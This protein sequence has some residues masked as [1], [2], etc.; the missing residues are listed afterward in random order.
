MLLVFR[1]GIS[2]VF[3]VGLDFD[4]FCIALLVGAVR[5]FLAQQREFLD[6]SYH[7]LPPDCGRW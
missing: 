5:R 7:C 6:A 3:L 1:V 2:V 4:G